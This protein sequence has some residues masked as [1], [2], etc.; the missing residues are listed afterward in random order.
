MVNTP[1]EITEKARDLYDAYRPQL[2][3]R[4]Q[5]KTLP[6]PKKVE[7]GYEYGGVFVSGNRQAGY[8]VPG[9]GKVGSLDEVKTAVDEHFERFTKE[10]EEL[11]VEFVAR[12]ELANELEFPE[13]K[14]LDKAKDFKV[15]ELGRKADKPMGKVGTFFDTGEDSLY[16]NVS[17]QLAGDV[18]ISAEDSL[19]EM[20]MFFDD[21]VIPLSPV[22]QAWRTNTEA[23]KAM[24]DYARGLNKRTEF[25]GRLKKA[26]VENEDL[27]N[28]VKYLDARAKVF[29]SYINTSR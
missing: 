12:K 10:I 4:N 11:Q 26:G 16:Y 3:T 23:A 8:D 24:L 28:V 6:K 7:G 20:N 9:V 18:K 2:E 22:V 5:S 15:Y 21:F 14:V 25:L 1:E 29:A 17:P 13:L 19:R 27:A